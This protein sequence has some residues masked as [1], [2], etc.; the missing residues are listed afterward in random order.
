[1]NALLT[2]AQAAWEAEE[3]GVLCT[4]VRLDG[5]G[6]GQPGARLFMTESG[7]R[8]GYISGG[9]LEKDL[10]RRAWEATANGPRLIAFDTRGH[11]VDADRYNTGCE[12]V[13]YVLCQR[14][15]A[16]HQFPLRIIEQVQTERQP[17]KLLTVYRTE[18]AAFQVGD[19]WAILGD[20]VLPS[21]ETTEAIVLERLLKTAASATKTQSLEILTADQKPVELALEI[22]RPPR[23]LIIFGAGDDVQPLVAMAALHGW[24][25]T[26]LGRR[27]ELA[28]PTRFPVA[29]V[30]CGRMASLVPSL[31]LHESSEVVMMTHDFDA[32]AELLPALLKTP[33]RS[34]G[35]L[36]PKRRLSRLVM[37]L[38]EQGV[39]LTPTN[40]ER[41]RSPI[42]L[43]LGAVT[44]QEIATS[45]MAEL[46]AMEHHREGGQLHQRQEPLHDR[47]AHQRLSP[48]LAV[49]ESP[50][51]LPVSCG[52]HS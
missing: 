50:I 45:I 21:R 29:T 46:I 27:P 48:N 47:A 1:M 14:V 35:L 37:R 17:A 6:Y 43:D 10:C 22:L 32:D 41:I 33:V 16:A 39:T 24:K 18:S 38:Y 20:R 23:E 34:I 26:V 30:H 52:I 9:C 28:A 19:S 3:T 49:S 8:T 40:A 12:G 51:K 42:G 15:D 36:G 7:E 44:P 4:V 13:V 31:S 11:A 5:S 2:M 25:I